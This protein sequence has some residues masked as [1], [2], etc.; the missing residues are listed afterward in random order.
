MIFERVISLRSWSPLDAS[1]PKV[2][3][4]LEPRIEEFAFKIPVMRAGTFNA[5]ITYRLTL[6]SLQGDPIASWSV[7][8]MGVTQ[9]R[10]GSMFTESMGEAADLAMQDSAKSFL[11]GF[12]EIPEVR[13]WLRQTGV[14]GDRWDPR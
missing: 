10:A 8:G 13:M 12:R 7:R 2:D 4:I 9:S 11:A 14:P 3:G 6:Y 1:P 5:E